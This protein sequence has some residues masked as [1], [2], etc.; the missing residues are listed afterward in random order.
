L[1]RRDVRLRDFRE[2][3]FFSTEA[4]YTDDSQLKG[5]AAYCHFDLRYEEFHRLLKAR[6]ELLKVLTHSQSLR[7]V[8]LT[9]LEGYFAHERS[10]PI[11][12]TDAQ[13]A[14]EA[15]EQRVKVLEGE[16]RASELRA[17]RIYRLARKVMPW[18]GQEPSFDA[19]DGAS[20][21]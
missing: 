20:S 14:E 19:L 1:Y 17:V 15:F 13:W 8:F 10:E 11:F 9:A 2:K 4:R 18:N 21:S 12:Q 5:A 7:L 16:Q 3:V 6:S